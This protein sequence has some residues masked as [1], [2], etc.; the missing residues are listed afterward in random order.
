MDREELTSAPCIFC[1]YNSSG[2][3]QKGTHGENCPWHEIGGLYEREKN[4][5]KLFINIYK[6]LS[7][8]IAYQSKADEKITEL[9]DKIIE[10]D[11]EIAEKS[12]A[13]ILLD[14]EIQVL[15]GL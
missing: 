2:Y 14:Q 7:E 10:L 5:P 1:G 3:Y 8:C 4:L 15:S 13:I 12:D 9:E 11:A 6:E